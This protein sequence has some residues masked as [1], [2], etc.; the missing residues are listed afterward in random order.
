MARF[1]ARLG[2]LPH[3]ALVELA[4]QLCEEGTEAQRALA[5][6]ALAVHAPLPQWA[7]ENVLL[8]PDLANHLLAP[9]EQRDYAAAAACSRLAAGGAPRRSRRR[10]G[11][12]RTAPCKNLP[13][14]GRI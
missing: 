1:A 6:A 9:L 5:D 7:V 4:A 12:P 2:A 13:Q 10:A 8:S 3:E 11:R 14:I